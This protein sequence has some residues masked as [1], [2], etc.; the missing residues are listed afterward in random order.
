MTADATPGV[1]DLES[2]A[3]S[4]AEDHVLVDPLFGNGRTEEVD[5]ALTEVVDGLGYP[6]YVVLAPGPEGLSGTD[7]GRDLATRLHERIGGDGLYVVQTDPKS[8]ALTFASF[9]DVPEATLR[10][11][12]ET[13][14]RPEGGAN[15]GLAPAGIA[16]RTLDVLDAVD[17]GEEVSEDRFDSWSGRTVFQEPAEWDLDYDVPT[18][19]T[20]AM[21]S[22]LAL[23]AVAGCSYLLLRTAFRWRETAPAAGPV[24]AA[25]RTGRTR[26]S[27]QRRAARGD[28]PA[29]APGP[30]EVRAT[31]ERELESLSRLLA[32][33]AGRP[34]GPE[35]RELVDGSYDTARSLLERTGTDP[36]DLDDLLGALVLVRVATRAAG[37]RKRSRRSARGQAQEQA[38]EQAQAPAPYRPCFF[39]P[40]HGEGTARR[41]VP[42]G[43]RELTV[44][45]CPRCTRATGT[46]LAPMV[47]RGG[48]LGRAR[49]WYELDTVWARTGYGAFV[50]DLWQHVAAD[51]RRSR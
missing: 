19:G 2:L 18:S 27:E 13:G 25:R 20:Y 42:V 3:G 4:L 33:G 31:A 14:L 32:R 21:G 28:A 34:L 29:P 9:G 7:P 37:T 44:P 50:D 46:A 10:Y 30:A 6:A 48:L 24:A 51:L 15:A 12:V 17:R 26:S 38:Q 41:T 49:P 8:H 5:A 36:A 35:Q 43:D 16:A 40:R 22:T 39:D 47:V 1:T 45:A 11:E 23:V